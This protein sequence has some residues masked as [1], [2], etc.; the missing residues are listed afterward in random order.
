VGPPSSRSHT[1]CPETPGFS[2]PLPNNEFFPRAAS[3]A[4]RLCFWN[5]RQTSSNAAPNRTVKL[6]RTFRFRAFY[7]TILCISLFAVVSLVVN[8]TA[9]YR[10]GVQYGAAQRRALEELNATRL[11]K[12][13]EEVRKNPHRLPRYS[14]FC[15][16]LTSLLHCSADLS[17][18]PKTSVPL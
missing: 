6:Q 2:I 11:V 3:I 4:R 7:I 10:H 8:Q 15:Y 1:Q 16:S 9:R 12:R 18:M 17:I 14:R 13:D 5:M